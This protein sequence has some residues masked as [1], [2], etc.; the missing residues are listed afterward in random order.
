MKKKV[1]AFILTGGSGV[2]VAAASRNKLPKQFINIAGKPVFIHCIEIYLKL[3]EVDRIY[4]VINQKHEKKYDTLLKKYHISGKVIKVPGGRTRL[5][6]VRNALDRVTESGGLVILQSGDCATTPARV[7]KKCIKLSRDKKA[8]SAY[9]PAF[10]T[11]FLYKK[12]ILR[13]PLERNETGYTC[14]PQVYDISVLRE[15]LNYAEKRG[16]KD[17]PT[18]DLVTRT[19]HRVFL[20]ESPKENMKITTEPDLKAVDFILRRKKL[21]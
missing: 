19:K 4:L 21:K 14:D 1:S 16:I 15:A 11:T 13:K 9:I 5:F 20:V 2:R 10:Y 18:V 8:V 17:K 6:S 3:K 7:I 12:N